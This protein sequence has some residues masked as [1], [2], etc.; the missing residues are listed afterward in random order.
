VRGFAS[1]LVGLTIG[2]VGIDF[3]TGQQRLTFGIPQLADGIDIIIV[4]VGIFAVGEALWVAAH[5]RR[6]AGT[7]IPVGRPW[8]G[9]DDWRRSWKPWLRGTAFGFPFG[10]IPAGG[11]EVPTFLSYLTERR[12]SKHRDEFG[13]GA[14]EGVAGPEAANNASAAGTLVPL[15]A[16]GIPT[17][18][19]AAI[20]LSALMGWGF[21]PG[22]FLIE[23]QPILVW[24]LVASLFVGNTM[25]LL[26]N[27]P[28]APAWAKLLQIPRPYLYA[29]ILFFATMGAYAVNAQ[30]F[31]LFL[32]LALGLLGFAM[33]R[34]GLP[35]LPLIIGVILGPLAEKHGRRALQLSGGDISGL[36]GGP[37]AWACYGIIVVV[38]L[39][40]LIARL[41][42]ALRGGPQR[43]DGPGPD[44]SGPD[45]ANQ[46]V[47]A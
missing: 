7:V 25:L 29:G 35:I 41:V 3:V 10:A 45:R 42:H 22:P 1:L 39:W 38:I 4:A 18:A 13:K 34:F 20:M 30:P 27:L 6:K 36:I 33:R 31:D 23:K 40:P 2:V 12:F 11:A 14:I 32:L 37:V 8:M 47:S 15:L 28:L 19:T 24:T 9:R 17:N 44:G 46:E 16:L 26:L 21:E 43:S 5:L